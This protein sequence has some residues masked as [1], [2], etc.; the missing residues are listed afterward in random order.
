MCPAN[1]EIDDGQQGRGCSICKECSSTFTKLGSGASPNVGGVERKSEK[2]V[3][4][5]L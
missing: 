4:R 5:F 3:V 1:L 2:A